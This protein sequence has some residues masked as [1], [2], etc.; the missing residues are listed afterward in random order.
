MTTITHEP[1]TVTL[2][3]SGA[4]PEDVVAVARHDAKVTISQEALEAVAKERG[5]RIPMQEGTTK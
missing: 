1:L 4:T 3:A 5:V 2:G